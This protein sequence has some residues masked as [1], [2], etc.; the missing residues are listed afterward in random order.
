MTTHDP[1]DRAIV[2]WLEADADQPVPDRFDAVMAQTRGRR[3]RP[4]WSSPERWLPVDLTS[5]A[6]VLAPPRLGRAL[7]I[8]LL[9]LALVGAVVVVGTRQQTLPAPFG[10]AAN[11]VILFS[12]GG[13][14]RIA[15]VDGGDSRTL[16]GGPARDIAPLL[17]PDGSRVLFFRTVAPDRFD[18]MAATVDGSG[19]R[20]LTAEPL[21]QPSWADWSPDGTRVLVV[22]TVDGRPTVSIVAADGSPGM[23]SLV[24]GPLMA[25]SPTWRP[26]DG[27][28]IVFRGT[29]AS[30]TAVYVVSADGG[31]PR[32]VAPIVTH[33]GGYLGLR[34]APDGGRVTY[35]HDQPITSAARGEERKSEVHVLDLGT[36][37]DDRVG[38]DPTSRHELL[39]KFSP[40]GANILLV[41]FIG[42]GADLILAAADGSDGAGRRIGPSQQGW[43]VGGGSMDAP[44]FEFSPDGRKVLLAIGADVRMQVIDL[45]TGAVEVGDFAEWPTWQRLA[46]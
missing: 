6:G 24:T 3:Q 22:H 4:W 14:I 7:L 16:I 31:E 39:P 19:V 10:P 18:L 37:E 36:G 1:F 40:D 30:G 2:A 29:T 32:Q 38:Y 26:P 33:D 34:L 5:R 11:G 8:V 35:W 21:T 46:P 43:G 45:A 13:D 41:R 42:D 27:R 44:M 9:V 15:G 12:A 17:S 23:R 20:S 28:E 25:D